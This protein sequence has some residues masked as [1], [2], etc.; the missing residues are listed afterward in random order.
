MARIA[1]LYNPDA[2]TQADIAPLPSGEYLAHITDSDMKPTK[3]ND[4]EYL[5]LEYTVIE[6]DCKGRKVW[7]RLNLDNPNAQTVDIANRQ[8][9][10]IREAT[11]VVNPQDSTELHYKPHFIRVEFIAAGTTQKNGYVTTKASNEVRSWRKAEGAQAQP[12]GR[13]SGSVSGTP[14]AAAAPWKR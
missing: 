3:K 14:A 11:G 6:G 9:A 4:G 10:S 2:E 8:M 12:T 1:G 5:E 7:A 13:S